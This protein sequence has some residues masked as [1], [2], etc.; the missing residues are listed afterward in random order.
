MPLLT[1]LARG[2]PVTAKVAAF[3]IDERTLARRLEVVCT[4]V[5]SMNIIIVLA[6]HRDH[7]VTGMSEK[8]QMTLLS[9]DITNPC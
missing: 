6:Q 4:G 3:M 7:V 9:I 2:C 5:V 1:W 8:P